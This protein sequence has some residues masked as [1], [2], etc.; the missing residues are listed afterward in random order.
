MVDH[1]FLEQEVHL[2]ST[3][4]NYKYKFIKQNYCLHLSD[5]FWPVLVVNNVFKRF[6]ASELRTIQ[7][8]FERVVPQRPNEVHAKGIFL[9]ILKKYQLSFQS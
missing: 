9:N 4:K 5:L 6:E 3:Y 7:N 1:C 8:D 2:P